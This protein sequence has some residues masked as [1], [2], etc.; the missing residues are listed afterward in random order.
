[1]IG[2]EIG[3]YRIVE[4]I[5]SG[6]MGVVYK[7]IDTQLD[8]V[9]AVKALN[10]EF[11]ANPTLLERFRTEARAQ[12]QLNH[13]NL[14]T[15]YALLVDEGAAYM[16]MEFVDGETFHEIVA[17]RGPIPAAEAVPLFRQALAGIGHAHRLGI[18]HR[19]IKPSNIMLNRE[20]VVK[21]MDFGLAK[22]AGSHGV[23]RTGT[24]LGTAYYM[25]PEQIL[26][27]PVDARSDIYSLGATL[28]EILAGHAPFRADSEFEI[29]NDHVNT[30]PPPPTSLQPQIPSGIEHAVMKALAKDPDS[31]FQTADQFSAALEHSEAFYQAA[32]AADP[33]PVEPGRRIAVVPRSFWSTRRKLLAGGGGALACLLAAWLIFRPQPKPQFTVQAPP[34]PMAAAPVPAA[35]PVVTEPVK[36]EP[37][38]GRIVVPSETRIAVRTADPIDPK[39]S[40]VGQE[41][42]ANLSAAVNVKDRAAFHANDEAHLR[43]GEAA[44]AGRSGK[45]ES[46]LELVSI[47]TGG[48]S[49]A[50]SSRPF[51]I[52]GGFL[53]KK[54]VA[55]GTQI[56]FRLSAPV[57]VTAPPSN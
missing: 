17:R 30:P 52:K 9:V 16:V 57:T 13:P 47:S 41:F 7:A 55:A 54:R 19:D 11:S 56:E 44:S 1:M 29:L 28:Y 4:K 21:V 2:T 46:I 23:T 51:V 20:G 24:R 3:S 50:V 6:G 35:P 15:L 14:A 34:R 26:A 49:Y 5:G 8:R 38:A 33:T 27:K 40:R 43:L 39:A 25:S 32:T 12:A 18:V 37:P 31:R 42:V 36:P 48:Q 10:P 53:R 45:P 22:V